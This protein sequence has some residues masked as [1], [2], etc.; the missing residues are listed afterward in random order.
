MRH[1][2]PRVGGLLKQVDTF[3]IT[4]LVG[5]ILFYICL[6]LG[7]N[8]F[9]IALG[10]IF[11]YQLFKTSP[12]IFKCKIRYTSALIGAL[13]PARKSHFYASIIFIGALRMVSHPIPTAVGYIGL[14]YPIFSRQLQYFCTV[15]LTDY[16]SLLIENISLQILSDFS[17][18]FISKWL[19]S[20]LND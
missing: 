13:A 20:F 1:N 9:P 14:T 15:K 6:N 8:L 5:Q 16:S 12:K 2:F 19:A 17:F 18:S 3:N 10:V 7:V 11:S 4:D